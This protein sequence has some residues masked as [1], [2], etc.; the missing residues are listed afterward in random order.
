[1]RSS[2]SLAVTAIILGSLACGGPAPEAGNSYVSESALDT[3]G[4]SAETGPSR[5]VVISVDQTDP[6]CSVDGTRFSHCVLVRTAADDFE[7]PESLCELHVSGGG[8]FLSQ[9]ELGSNTEDEVE[10]LDEAPLHCP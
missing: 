6:G 3:I 10:E 5:L 1:M 9:C 7:G 2:S 4:D 8:S